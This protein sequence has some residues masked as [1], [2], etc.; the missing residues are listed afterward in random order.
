MCRKGPV[1]WQDTIQ[2]IGL[3]KGAAV[4][5]EGRLTQRG[6]RSEAL[7]PPRIREKGSWL[8]PH[9]LK[10]KPQHPLDLANGVLLKFSLLLL[11]INQKLPRPTS[12]P[13]WSSHKDL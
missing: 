5:T 9:S 1:A 3:S 13:F 11:S 6:H 10:E 12:W 2:G 8:H 4:G 7:K